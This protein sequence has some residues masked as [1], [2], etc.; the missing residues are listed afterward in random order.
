MAKGFDK[1]QERQAALA[2]FGRDLARRAGSKCELC[3]R[4]G[5]ALRVYEVPPAPR[6]P[7]IDAC[8]FLCDECREQIER[9]RSLQPERWRFLVNT[10]WSET[11]AAQVMAARLLGAIG[12]GEAWAREALSEAHFDEEIEAWIARERI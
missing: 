8:L 1:H 7:D 11:P 6:E 3:E 4:G 9:P 12:R 2:S 10:V 5:L